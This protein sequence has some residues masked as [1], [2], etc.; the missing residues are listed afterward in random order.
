VRQGSPD[1][2]IIGAGVIGLACAVSLAEAGLRVVVIERRGPGAGSSTRNGGGVRSQLGTETNIRMS[3]L[4]APFWASFEDRFRVDIRLR[5]I[6]YLFLA[7]D[8]AAMDTIRGQVALQNTLGVRSEAVSADEIGHRWP[9]L[10]RLDVAGAGFCADD[11]YLNQHRVIWGLFEAARSA[12]V[13]F[14]LETEV[15]CVREPV[16]S[17]ISRRRAARSPLASRSTLLARGRLRSTTVTYQLGLRS[18]PAGSS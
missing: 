10:R 16:R 5:R 2:A 1:V 3:V 8:D 17:P 14:E 15:L 9:S 7:G 12:G 13:R 11:G 18:G 4:S 6:G